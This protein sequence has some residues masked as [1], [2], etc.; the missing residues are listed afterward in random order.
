MPTILIASAMPAGWLGIQ[1]RRLE[2]LLSLQ[3][4]HAEEL[5]ASGHRLLQQATFTTY[6]ECRELGGEQLAA[7]MLAA[8]QASVG[9]DLKSGAAPSARSG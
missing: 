4:A 9:A 6:M 1:L 5:N 7:E 3:R 2:R 8:H